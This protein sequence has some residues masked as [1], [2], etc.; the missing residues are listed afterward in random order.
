MGIMALDVRKIVQ[1]V[2]HGVVA[3]CAQILAIAS[4]NY[5]NFCSTGRPRDVICVFAPLDVTDDG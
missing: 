5:A 3:V 1:V 4:L 2:L